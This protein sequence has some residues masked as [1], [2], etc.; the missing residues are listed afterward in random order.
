[1]EHG[2]HIE[3]DNFLGMMLQLLLT[4]GPGEDCSQWKM[5]KGFFSSSCTG[6]LTI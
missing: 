4:V 6:V 1:M 3:L 2:N 5:K